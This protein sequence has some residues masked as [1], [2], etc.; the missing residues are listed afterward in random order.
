MP[1]KTIPLVTCEKHTE[2]LLNKCQSVN[3]LSL[4]VSVFGN[5]RF[6][7]S[8][9]RSQNVI[10]FSIIAMPKKSCFTIFM[11]QNLVQNM[12][13]SWINLDH[14]CKA[15]EWCLVDCFHRKFRIFTEIM[16]H[17]YYNMKC[18]TFSTCDELLMAFWAPFFAFQNIYIDSNSEIIFD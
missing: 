15:N 18:K 6:K 11:I 13:N 10:Y 4:D 12:K 9:S 8:V 14:V 3:S 7:L 2:H 16:V 1:Q 5:S 17:Y